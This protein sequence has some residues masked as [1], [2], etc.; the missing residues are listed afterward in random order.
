[1]KRIGRKKSGLPPIFPALT[2]YIGEVMRR[3]LK[4]GVWQMRPPRHPRDRWTPWLVD[5]REHEY[6]V[7]AFSN[8]LD[9]DNGPIMIHGAAWIEYQ[10]GLRF[11]PPHKRKPLPPGWRGSRPIPIMGDDPPPDDE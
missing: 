8:G 4:G 6:N 1:V 3:S 10:H 5:S 9:P 7:L 11:L 2:A